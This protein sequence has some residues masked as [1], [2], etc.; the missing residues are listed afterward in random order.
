MIQDSNFTSVLEVAAG[1]CRNTE[2]LL[3]LADRVI[4]TEINTSAIK[5]CKHRFHGRPEG[6][7]IEYIVVDGMHVPQPNES[8]SFVYQF[9]SGVHFHR[10]VI[11]P[12]LKEFERLL[13]PGGTGFFH[14][15]NLRGS[16]EVVVSDIDIM[17]NKHNR[18][19]MTRDEFESIAYEAGLEVYCNPLVD[20]GK[21]PGLD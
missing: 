13:V 1:A 5:I 7:K 3:P 10:R 11:Q 8:V 20:W 17:K 2:K 6:K 16:D 15:S 21:V 19:N 18:A 9:D 4:V 12:Y 14:Y